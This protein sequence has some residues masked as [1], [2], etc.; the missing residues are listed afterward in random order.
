MIIAVGADHRGFEAKQ[1]LVAEL[2]AAGHTVKDLGANTHD[3]QD[4]YP[5]F[6]TAVAQVVAAEAAD[7]GILLCDTSGGM[8]ITANKVA[9][10]RAVSCS[11]P[12]Q[13]RHA[14]THNHANVL[15][16]AAGELEWPTLQSVVQTFITTPFDNA[17]RHQRRVAQITALET[18]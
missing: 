15:S 11:T 8:T 17:E 6:A 4:D 18:L 1:R 10:I 12:E 13:A 7:L 16:L 9:G 5:V 14:R 3:P 2:R